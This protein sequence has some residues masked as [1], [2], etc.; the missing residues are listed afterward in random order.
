MS[1]AYLWEGN[2]HQLLQEMISSSVDAILVKVASIGLNSTHLGKSLVQMF[3]TLDSLS[4]KFGVNVC[5]EGG[6]FESLTLDCP[7]FRKKLIIDESEVIHHDK[8]ELAPVAYLKIKK[9]H[10]EAKNPQMTYDKPDVVLVD[11]EYRFEIPDTCIPQSEYM[12]N[13]SSLSFGIMN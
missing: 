7:M 11:P 6:E 8:D 12:V 10:L 3:P 2:Q 1:L 13:I 9:Y 4:Q 5:G